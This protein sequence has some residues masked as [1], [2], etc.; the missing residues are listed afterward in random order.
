MEFINITGYEE[1]YEVSANG[2]IKN[3]KKNKIMKPSIDSRGYYQVH[4]SQKGK[5]KKISVH[6]LVAIAFVLNP[7]NKN[8]VNHIDG[9]K[10]NNKAENL[11]WCTISE[12]IKHAW[13]MG[14]CKMTQ[15]N[16]D[17]A[18]KLHSKPVLDLNT[19]IMFDSV[20]KASEALNFNYQTAIKH[21]G[22]KVKQPRFI[23]V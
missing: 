2:D 22:K 9:N 15:K 13:S 20:R 17:T 5:A 3:K 12:N 18:S 10:Q 19:G 16:R 23:Y 4:F 7:L 14:L 8:Q 6:R 21:L 11:E 1:S